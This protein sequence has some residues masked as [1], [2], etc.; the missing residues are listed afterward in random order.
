MGATEFAVVAGSRSTAS[1]RPNSPFSTLSPFNIVPH[2]E[3]ELAAA[4]ARKHEQLVRHRRQVLSVCLL[5]TQACLPHSLLEVFFGA[6][7]QAQSHTHT[8]LETHA[9]TLKRT[10]AQ[11]RRLSS[12]AA[13]KRRAIRP[14]LHGAPSATSVH[15]RASQAH[16]GSLNYSAHSQLTATSLTAGRSAGLLSR[17]RCLPTARCAG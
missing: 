9:H 12:T 5:G 1:P 2:R 15:S 17:G 6:T 8:C 14:M 7:A 13:P 10:S 16:R 4:P 11:S 3:D